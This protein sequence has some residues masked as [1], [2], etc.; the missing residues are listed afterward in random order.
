[1]GKFEILKTKQITRALL[2]VVDPHSEDKMLSFKALKNEG[3]Y[4]SI[5]VCEVGDAY[6][7]V[8]GSKYFDT[9]KKSGIKKILVYNCGK[10]SREEYLYRR[11]ILN[12]NQ[13]RLSYLNIA[14]HI[15]ELVDSK[16]KITNISNRTSL[17]LQE[18]ER[19]STLLDFN[20][21]EFNKVQFKQQTNPFE[22]E[23]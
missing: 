12:I 16:I 14:K 21:D 13:E 3:Q 5:M 22:N 2:D 4:K 8:D 1:M 23:R 15:K 18:V 9:L 6:L 11:L 19:F 20:W 10:L 7:V 17:K